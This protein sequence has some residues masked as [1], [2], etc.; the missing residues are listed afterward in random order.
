MLPD[1]RILWSVAIAILLPLGVAVAIWRV[2]A[3]ARTPQGSVAW[4]TFLLAAPWFALPA[5]LFFGHHKLHGYKKRRRISHQVMKKFGGYARKVEPREALPEHA[6]FARL[7]EMP[8]TGCNSLRLLVDGDETFGAIHAAIDR[9]QSYVLVQYYTIV[10]DSTGDA[11]ADRLIAAAARDVDVRLIYDGVGSYG[12]DHRYIDRLRKAGVVVVDPRGARGP[13]SRF[14]LNFRN[15]RKTVIVDGVEGFTGGLNMSDTYRGLNAKSGPWRDT[16]LHLQGP[17]VAQL[18]LSYV[19]DW[20]WATDEALGTRLNWMPDPEE[21]GADAVVVPM[22]PVDELDTGSL[23]YVTAIAQARRRVWIATPYLV[24]DGEV[25]AALKS[26]ALR[27][28][29]VR[30]LLPEGRDHWSTWLA[31]FS[32][33]DELRLAGVAIWRFQAGF[34]HQKVILVDNALAGVGTANLDN[35]SFRL[36]FETMV[37]VFDDGFCQRVAAMLDKDFASATNLVTSL[38][39][40]PLWLRVGA[41]AARLLAPVL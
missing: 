26:A 34:M 37:T 17:A 20:H 10:A 25:L 36:N 41:R 31:A 12:L 7:A 35:R 22:G 23:Y 2:L 14:Q 15:H 4:V 13:T 39:D 38:D 6:A 11:L 19:E 9:A 32:Y 33:F 21:G 30:I 1:L 18:Q 3:N 28:C 8:V 24:P 40:Q 5:Y 27:G 16:H 29:D